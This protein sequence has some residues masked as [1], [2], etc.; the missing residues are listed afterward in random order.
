M[1]ARRAWWSAAA[2]RSAA[3]ESC[4]RPP[5]AGS[6]MLATHSLGP[7]AQ[8]SPACHP[9][10][11][12]QARRPPVPGDAGGEE[13]DRTDE[14]AA[15]VNRSTP[16]S[17]VSA[18]LGRWQ[19][20]SDPFPPGPSGTNTPITPQPWQAR[21]VLAGGPPR[22]KWNGSPVREVARQGCSSCRVLTHAVTVVRTAEWVLPVTNPSPHRCRPRVATR[23]PEVPA[24]K[25]AQMRLTSGSVVH[26]AGRPCGAREAA[27]RYALASTYSGGPALSTRRLR[28]RGQLATM[29]IGD[30]GGDAGLA[31][32]LDSGP[33]CSRLRA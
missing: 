14:C 8:P 19:Q 17:A 28:G 32:G 26:G 5:T 15:V 23:K 7:V 4:T 13:E 33:R 9:G 3:R 2:P 25:N 29:R 11:A 30:P 20:R 10:A 27:L 22:S 21:S 12:D 6:A 1:A 24:E 31:G 16:R 18:G